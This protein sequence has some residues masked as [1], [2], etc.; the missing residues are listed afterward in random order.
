MDGEFTIESWVKVDDDGW[1][2][3]RRTLIANN[4]GWTTNHFAISLMNSGNSVEENCITLWDYNANSGGSVASSSPVKVETSDGWTH[5]AVTRDSSNNIRIFKNG[6]QAG[7][8]YNSSN[9]YLFGTG[10]TWIGQITMSNLSGAESLDGKIS[11]LRIVKGQALY[12]SS[13]TPALSFTTTSQGAT[14]SNVKLLCCNTITTTG[15]NVSPASIN[16]NGDPT[17]QSESVNG[18]TTG[19]IDFDGS[20]DYLNT[21]HS[22]DYDF[23]SGDFTVEAWVRPTNNQQTDPSMVALWN[24][25]QGRRSWGIFGNTGGSPSSYNG[26]VRG[27]VSP[28]G[29]FATRTEITGTLTLNSWNHVA[30]TRSGN[31]LYFFINGNSQGTASY[32]GSVYSNTQDSVMVGAMGNPSDPRNDFNGKISNVRVIKGTALY[33][34]NFTSPTAP[35]TEVTNTKLLCCQ[36]S[37]STIGAAVSPTSITA[38]GDAASQETVVP[39]SWD[40]GYGSVFFDGDADSVSHAATGDYNLDGDWCIECWVNSTDVSLTSGLYKRIWSL[41]RTSN[42]SDALYQGLCGSWEDVFN[43]GGDGVFKL[44]IDDQVTLASSTIASDGNWHHFVVQRGGST[45]SLHVDG[46]LEA[47]TSYSSNVN[48][49]VNTFKIGEHHVFMQGVAGYYSSFPGKISNFRFVN[50]STV[51]PVGSSFTVPTEPLKAITNTV[52]LSCNDPSNAESGTAGPVISKGGNAVHDTSHP[53]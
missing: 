13:F 24:F 8:T 36:D 15:A 3:V 22:N 52:L 35:L 49:S 19:T 32:T 28:D 11:N 2:G 41:A 16:S 4:I 5:I 31:T 44:R 9:S 51:Y 42:N 18:F 6:T 40:G 23:G 10:E 14:A 37:S 43:A 53:F 12:T 34:S 7:S 33:T 17:A 48:Y 50:G 29:Q 20:G 38:K 21:S 30:F 25:P 26:A 39:S 46:V 45:I 27:T 1:S 47:T